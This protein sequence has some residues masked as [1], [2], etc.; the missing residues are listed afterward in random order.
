MNNRRLGFAA[1]LTALVAVSPASPA[2][3]NGGPPTSIA[4]LGDSITTAACANGVSCSDALPDSWST[5]TSVAVQSHLLRLRAIW[6]NRHPVRAVNLAS[7]D[8]VTMAD[9]PAQAR[10]AL[11]FGANYVTIEIGENDL[12]GSTSIAAFRA[13]L[14]QGLDILSSNDTR[15]PVTKILLLSIEDIVAHWRVLHDNPVAR[16]R[17][18]TG[19][20]LDCALGDQVPKTWLAQIQERARALNA[21]EAD[22]CSTVPY[23]LYDGG[24]YY[25]LPLRAA[26]FSPADYQHL[27]LAG[28]RAL[29][30]AEWKVALRV[31]Y[32]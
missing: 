1:A 5:G 4:A 24:T 9:L 21:V 26:Y 11:R 8:D 19:D 13:Q 3:H 32:D 28:Q 27:S 30:A 17:F 15:G 10:Q 20:S 12:C 18:K 22:V 7:D 23:C 2:T 16:K 29:A 14:K 31:L 6:K 25:H